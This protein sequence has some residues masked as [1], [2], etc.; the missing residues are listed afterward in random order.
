MAASSP[1]YHLSTSHRSVSWHG[2]LTTAAPLGCENPNVGCDTRSLV[3]TAPKGTWITVSVDS[4]TGDDQ[5]RVTHDGAVVGNAGIDFAEPTGNTTPST[6]F[7]QLAGGPVRYDVTVGTVTATVLTPDDFTVT[8]KLAGRAFDRAGDCPIANLDGLTDSSGGQMPTLRVL[9]V[10]R[11]ADA[12]AVHQAG[13]TLTEIYKRIAV[14]VHV[15]YSFFDWKMASTDSFPYEA[16]RR[17]FGGVRP[18]GVDVVMVLTDEFAGGQADCIG[19][20]RYPEKAFAVGDVHYTVQGTVP[21]DSVPA[22]MI[23]AH[24]IGH[25]LGAQH[26]QSNCVEALPQE[27]AQPASDGWTG[28]CTL[29]GPAALQD[30]ETFS[31]LERNTIRMFVKDYVGR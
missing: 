16:V 1:A 6:V 31:T 26:N 28:P 11:P 13:R 10:A 5:L 9:L 25:L 17:H 8:A 19:G 23:A 2:T 15:S 3:V 18:P 14:P 22:G 29:M 12:A 30:S 24:E 4:P 7:Q 20:V 27:A 21:V